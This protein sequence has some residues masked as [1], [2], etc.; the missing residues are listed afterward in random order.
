MWKQQHL[1]TKSESQALEQ[2]GP[3]L[4][5]LL[6]VLQVQVQTRVQVQKQKQKQKQQ[7]LHHGVPHE[8]KQVE[9][10][11]TRGSGTSTCTLTR[12]QQT[13]WLAWQWEWA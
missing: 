13:G 1:P 7:N 4:H 11:P 9:E 12:Y 6:Q 10:A 5:L 2:G 3:S 8:R